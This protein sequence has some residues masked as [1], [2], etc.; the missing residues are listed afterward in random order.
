[1][2]F[3]TRDGGVQIRNQLRLIQR[4][5]NRYENEYEECA[6]SAEYHSEGLVYQWEEMLLP[7]TD[8]DESDRDIPD[9][10]TSSYSSDT[11][12]LLEDLSSG[13]SSTDDDESSHNTAKKRKTSTSEVRS[14]TIVKDCLK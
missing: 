8:H 6:Q 10:D 11:S 9:S 1:M 4:Q 5:L 13:S 14:I 7:E 2:P 3:N 12:F